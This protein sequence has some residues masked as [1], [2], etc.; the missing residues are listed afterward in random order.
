MKNNVWFIKFFHTY[1]ENFIFNLNQKFNFMKKFS[2]LLLAVSFA[3]SVL[4][5]CEN[6]NIAPEAELVSAEIISQIKSMGFSTEGV[7]KFESGYLVENDIY[8]TK[9][10]LASNKKGDRLPILEQ[11]STNNLV[12][13]P[14]NITMYAPVG[15]RNGYSSGMIAGL[16][17]AISRYNAQNLS[18]T[19]SRVS[20]SA[21]ADIVMTRLSKGDERRG[22]L[23]SA[24]FPTSSCDPYGEIKMSG[25]LE[26][27]YGLSTGGIAT[28]IGHEMGHCIGFR[29]TDYFDRSI[30]C[31]GGTSNEGASTVG[32]NHIPGTPT[33]A[34]L[35]AKSWMLACT[36]GSD[37]PFNNDDRTALN[38]LY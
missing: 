11:Y 35:A 25:I 37:R 7:M 8:L 30:S 19:F 26:S 33:G 4:M 27:S 24:G 15:G 34:T 36:D 22:V 9:E 10:D 38:Y 31:G 5:S 2:S 6:Q 17:L 21:G 1:C 20:S 32:A 23:G 13:G 18:I 29:H 3:G 28:I 14:R 12:C 16:D